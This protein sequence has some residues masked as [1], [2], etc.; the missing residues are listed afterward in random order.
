MRDPGRQTQLGGHLLQRLGHTGRVQPPGIGDHLDIFFQAGGH[1]GFHLFEKGGNVAGF[2]RFEFFLEQDGHGQFG[3]VVT[4]QDING[5]ARDHLFRSRKAVT[6]KT[7][8][9]G[10]NQFV[11]VV[12]VCHV[13]I[14][15]YFLKTLKPDFS[16]RVAEARRKAEPEFRRTIVRK[17]LLRFLQQR[18]LRFYPAKPEILML[19]SAPPRLCAMHAL[20]IHFVRH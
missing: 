17:P 9:I 11:V 19:F 16:R 4:G 14:T 18:L 6:I 1:D 10:D 8:A 2:R 7:T 3:E 15:S 20:V 13:F 5:S 12:G